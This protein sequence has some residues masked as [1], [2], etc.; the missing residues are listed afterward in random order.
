MRWFNN[1]AWVWAQSMDPYFEGHIYVKSDDDTRC[2]ISYTRGHICHLTQFDKHALPA[3]F[4]QLKTAVGWCEHLVQQIK[5]YCKEWQP[6]WDR[7]RL[8]FNPTENNTK[9]SAACCC[10]CLCTTAVRT[11]THIWRVCQGSLK[12]KSAFSINIG[13]STTTASCA[14]GPCGHFPAARERS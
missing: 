7:Q 12:D 9:R 5:T 6:S 4:I 10:C 11:R 13:V 8:T 2:M 14:T 3:C 1:T